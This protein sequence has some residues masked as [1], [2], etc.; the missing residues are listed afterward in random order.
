[1]T[2]SEAIAERGRDFEEVMDEREEE[3]ERLAAFPEKKTTVAPMPSA[4][5]DQEEKSHAAV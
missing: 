2:Y 4:A 3:E 1:M 5:F